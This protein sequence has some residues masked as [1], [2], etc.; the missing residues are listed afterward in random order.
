MPEDGLPLK[1]VY[2][3][4]LYHAAIKVLQEAMAKIEEQ[5]TQIES[6]KAEINALK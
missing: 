1:A 5:Q 6:L 3:N 2:T 4:D